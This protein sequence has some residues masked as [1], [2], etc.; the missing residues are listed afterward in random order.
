MLLI[1]TVLFIIG[2]ALLYFGAEGL[3][4]G[5]SRLARSLG[6][7]PIV[8]GLTVVAFGTSSPE[9]VVSLIA[10]L[11]KSSDIAVGNIIGSNIANIGLILGVSALIS[12]LKVRLSTLKR[13]LP[14]MVIASGLLFLMAWD[15][16]ISFWDGLVLFLGIILFTSSLIYVFLKR[17]RERPRVEEEFKDLV[18][19]DASKGRNVLLLFLGLA[20]LIAGAHLMVRSAIVIARGLGVDELVIGL[21]VVALGTSLPELGTSAVAAYRKEGDISIGNV[22]GSNLFNILF[23]IGSVA[24][25]NPIS[26]KPRTLRFEFPAMML[27]SI[28]L[29]PLMKTSFTINRIE[30]A[31]LVLAYFAFLV[32][33]F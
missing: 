18:K 28:A 1:P 33:L 12:P 2:V 17:R 25:L 15:L 3:V 14:V 32:L 29:F 23:V 27:F 13:E 31:M 19:V 7:R 26:V 30:G 4:K 11:K 8:I 6:I 10:V 21:T 24:L 20:G 5:S 22:I 16:K 9:F